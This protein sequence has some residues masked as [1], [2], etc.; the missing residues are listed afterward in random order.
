LEPYQSVWIGDNEIHLEATR[1]TVWLD[2]IRGRFTPEQ[3]RELSAKLLEQAVVA[4]HWK[5]RR[6]TPKV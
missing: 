2:V 6:K 1:D 3:A 5:G 4:E